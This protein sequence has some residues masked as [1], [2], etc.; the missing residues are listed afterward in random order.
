M[1]L[2][3]AC[4]LFAACDD[5]FRVEAVASLPASIAS[6]TANGDAVALRPSNGTLELLYTRDFD[7]YRSASGQQI[8]FVFTASDASTTTLDIPLSSCEDACAS[9][10]CPTAAEI[11]LERL[12]LEPFAT[13]YGR[14]AMDCIGDGKVAAVIP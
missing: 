12:H 10:N 4:L 13:S 2:A 8:V 3:L 7:S 9:P 1:R 11:R 5:G 6:V 14:Y